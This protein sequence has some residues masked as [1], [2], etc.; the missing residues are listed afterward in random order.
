[1]YFNGIRNEQHASV[2]QLVE[3]HVANVIVAGSSPVSRSIL[4][5]KPI[6]AKL[7]VF[8]Y[9]RHSAVAEGFRLRCDYAVTSWRDKG[10]PDRNQPFLAIKNQ[11]TFSTEPLNLL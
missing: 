1:M 6:T 4:N 3:H 11:S 9:M 5:I 2:A 10:T 7:S 8:L